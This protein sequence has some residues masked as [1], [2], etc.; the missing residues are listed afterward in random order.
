MSNSFNKSKS[1]SKGI[2]NDEDDDSLKL[3]E[4][5][6]KTRGKREKEEE[7]ALFS[8]SGVSFQIY[9]RIFAGIKKRMKAK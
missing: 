9:T 2:K 5:S 4:F 6:V 3:I 1:D 7:R 8:S